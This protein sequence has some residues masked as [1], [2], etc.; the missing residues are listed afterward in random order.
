MYFFSYLFNIRLKKNI[1]RPDIKIRK[2]GRFYYGVPADE[3]LSITRLL[4]PGDAIALD[5]TK[6]NT[7]RVIHPLPGGVIRI[8]QACHSPMPGSAQ[9][10]NV[11][12]HG[13][14]TFTTESQE[15]RVPPTV[16]TCHLWHVAIP[17][18]SFQIVA[19]SAG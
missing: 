17:C 16:N 10:C 6:P 12:L 14:P 2:R 1:K 15:K 11:K 9:F 7:R 8:C 5:Q 4:R 3:R 19:C 13:P 18:Y